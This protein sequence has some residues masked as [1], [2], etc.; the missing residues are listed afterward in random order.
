MKKMIAL[1]LTISMVLVLFASCS[2][3]NASS[4][5]E[6]E[7]GAAVDNAES[8]PSTDAEEVEPSVEPD[9]VFAEVEA[10]ELV[11]P[12]SDELVT[13]TAYRMADDPEDL[14][15]NVAL[16][17]LEKRTN[18]HIEWT[19][20]SGLDAEP[21]YLFIA[22]QDYTDL[23]MIRTA[24]YQGGIDKAIED[25]VYTDGADYLDLMPNFSRL[26]ASDPDIARQ[27]KTDEGTVMFSGINKNIQP[28][29]IGPMVRGD[30]LDDLG[31]DVPVTYDDWHEMLT[32]FKNEK[33]ASA[34][35][36]INSTGYSG[37]SYGLT[38]GYGTI[39]DFYAENGTEVKFGFMED[40]MKEYLQMIKEWFAE[41][42]VD[43]DFISHNPFMDG[44]TIYATG[45]TGAFED[46]LYMMLEVM[47]LSNS[48]AG[49]FSNSDAGNYLVPVPLPSKTE[50]E[51][52]SL[53][54]GL[55]NNYTTNDSIF[56]ST[57]AV[58][59]GVDELCAR[60]IDYR[61]SEEGSLLLNYGVEGI[62]YELDAE[63]N[64]VFTELIMNNPNNTALEMLGDYAEQGVGILYEW[65]REKQLYTPETLSA[66]DVWGSSTACDWVM[67][68]ITMTA[69][70][71]EE[72]TATYND[73]SAYIDTTVLQF[74]FGQKSLDDWD[75]FVATIESLGIDR[76]I[77][78]KQDA[79]NRYNAR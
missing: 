13:I 28:A 29:Y 32:A 53:H 61:Y 12:I 10:E 46:Q 17:E 57:D 69:E 66:Y 20:Y 5:P 23:I 65:E 40:G 2:S 25:E 71:A 16:N 18:V 11:L 8:A 34:P 1:L 37:F 31:L 9:N 38:S 42:L 39:G 24:L 77:Q 19:T 56:I 79:L 22:S 48:D 27:C 4:T 52:G 43:P 60:W 75:E 54:F 74:I 45:A 35:V 58:S 50:Q 73:I 6:P 67:P 3:T 21:F 76:C 14:Y 62:S 33:G 68:P 70:E 7:T 55:A 59:R 64:P 26:L 30:W 78:I 63:G 49:N 44:S 51:Q 36:V 15:N 72:F 41:G 47:P